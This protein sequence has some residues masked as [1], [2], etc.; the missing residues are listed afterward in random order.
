[1]KKWQV[2]PKP[3]II[4]AC[5]LRVRNVALH[6]QKVQW[7]LLTHGSGHTR[8]TF[9]S[10]KAQQE[11]LQQDYNIVHWHC[12]SSGM[13]K[14]VENNLPFLPPK[15]AV[16]V[17]DGRVHAPLDWRFQIIFLPIQLIANGSYFIPFNM[18]VFAEEKAPSYIYRYS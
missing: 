14:K 15:L 6:L 2:D 12:G 4:S 13:W 8:N 9:H 11:D 7:E 18:S 10:E 17:A 3:A 16:P 5:L 1:M